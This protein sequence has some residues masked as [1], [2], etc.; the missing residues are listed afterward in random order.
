MYDI[1]IYIYIYRCIDVY[2]CIYVYRLF[3]CQVSSDAQLFTLLIGDTLLLR[4]TYRSHKIDLV[5]L[6]FQDLFKEIPG[7]DE[8]TRCRYL[9]K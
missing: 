2:R 3:F 9:D 8:K 4:I 6:L 7:H 5:S 1:Y